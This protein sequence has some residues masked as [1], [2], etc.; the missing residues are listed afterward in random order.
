MA[1]YD[2]TPA[3]DIRRAITSGAITGDNDPALIAD[4]MIAAADRPEA[5]LRLPLGPDCYQ[6]VRAALVARLENH[7]AH[8]D[9]ALS[10]A[11]DV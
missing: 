5:P 10:V 8:R 4:A 3:G 9:I 6:Y 11:A 7:E 2:A 1:A